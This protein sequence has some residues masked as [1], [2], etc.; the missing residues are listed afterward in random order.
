M[1]PSTKQSFA[2]VRVCQMLSNSYR[3]IYVFRYDT[4]RQIFYIQAGTANQ[5][6]EIEIEILRSG[7]WRFIE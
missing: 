5:N 6:D 1:E 4:T 2:C 3:A 7:L